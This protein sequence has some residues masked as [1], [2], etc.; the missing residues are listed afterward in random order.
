MRGERVSIYAPTNDEYYRVVNHRI[1]YIL[2]NRTEYVK[3]SLFLKFY[4]PMANFHKVIKLL[5]S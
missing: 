1:G 4:G 2:Y 5:S 3:N